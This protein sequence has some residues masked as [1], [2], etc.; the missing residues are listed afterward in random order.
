MKLLTV[1]QVA[2]RLQSSTR[3]VQDEIRR[4]NLRASKLNGWR[5]S[6]DDLQTYIDAKANVSTVRRSA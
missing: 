4:K 3:Y 1:V 2:D 5:V 6:E